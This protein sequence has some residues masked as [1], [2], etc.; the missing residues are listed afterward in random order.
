MGDEHLERTPTSG[1]RRGGGAQRRAASVSSCRITSS[2]R[3]PNGEKTSRKRNV[4]VQVGRPLSS[5]GVAGG[6]VPKGVPK[7]E[8]EGESV[9]GEA[10]AISSACRVDGTC[11]TRSESESQAEKR[12][13]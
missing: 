2:E 10:G 8:I 13:A 4:R 11:R 3:D 12:E 9:A 6:G 1:R 5:V 7:G